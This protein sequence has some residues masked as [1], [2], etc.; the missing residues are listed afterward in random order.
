MIKKQVII[1]GAGPAG[2]TSAIQLRRM[3]IDFAIIEKHK[4]GGLLRNANLIE[5]Y[6]G[7][8]AGVKGTQL[9][10]LMDK[11]LKNLDIIPIADEVL[12]VEFNAGFFRIVGAKDEYK[13][14]Y[15]IVASGTV[16]NS[17]GTVSI[18]D[19]LIN[20]SVFYEV[21]DIPDRKVNTISIVGSGDAAFDYA[22]NLC[23]YAAQINIFMRGTNCKALQLL[24]DRVSKTKNVEVY[25]EYLLS[26]IEKDT[27]GLKLNFNH[28]NNIAEFK[29]D[30]LIFAIGRK[31]NLEFIKIGEQAKVDLVSSVKLFLAGD[32][33]NGNMRQCSIAVADGMKAAMSIDFSIGGGGK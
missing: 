12:S 25:Q 17:D 10:G 3:N 7:F 20:Q 33:I 32:I 4:I 23:G 24:Q 27:N 15:L 9:S 30:Y 31:P 21:A 2:V 6:A 14:E 18:P 5:N 19:G 11:H 1:I 16:Q 29:S 22:L 26:G 13:S 8:P 28:K